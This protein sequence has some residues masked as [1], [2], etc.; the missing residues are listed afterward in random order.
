MSDMEE[1]AAKLELSEMIDLVQAEIRTA[2]AKVGIT[3]PLE[4]VSGR[5]S[6]KV[7]AYRDGYETGDR[8]FCAGSG[9]Q[10]RTR[11]CAH[12]QDEHG[13]GGCTAMVG[14][15]RLCSCERKNGR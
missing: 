13:P 4:N 8:P 10:L 5:E 6:V 1:A 12:R 3:Y 2:F 7:A 15:K 11:G 9:S 14:D